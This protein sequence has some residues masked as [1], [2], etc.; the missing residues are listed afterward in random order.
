MTAI[1]QG[2][3]VAIGIGDYAYPE[4]GYPT[5]AALVDEVVKL[6][7][8]VGREIASPQEARKMLGI[9]NPSS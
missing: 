5:N 7:R 6:A 4:L 3:H 9:A 2:G 8:L 1:E